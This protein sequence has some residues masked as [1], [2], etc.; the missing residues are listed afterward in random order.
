MNL[1]KQMAT[2]NHIPSSGEALDTWVT[3]NTVYWQDSK[4]FKTPPEEYA[5][6]NLV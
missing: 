3:S 2:K 4:S 1:N 6:I 5:S